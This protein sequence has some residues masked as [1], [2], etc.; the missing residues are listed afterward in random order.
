MM[1]PFRPPGPWKMALMIRYRKALR[2][3]RKKMIPPH[4]PRAWLVVYRVSARIS[5]RNSSGS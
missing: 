1:I 3:I 4:T 2:L 5:F